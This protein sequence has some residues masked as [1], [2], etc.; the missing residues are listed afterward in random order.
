[1]TDYTVIGETIGS[2]LAL[3][4]PFAVGW[5]LYRKYLKEKHEDK[6]EQINWDLEHKK[7][8]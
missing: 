2:F 6:E 3:V 8:E 1:M 4:I 7:D 5:W